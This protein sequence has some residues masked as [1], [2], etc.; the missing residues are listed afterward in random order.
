MGEGN[1]KKQ[2]KK[3]SSVSHSH[4]YDEDEK[5]EKKKSGRRMRRRRREGILIFSPYCLCFLPACLV[6][7]LSGR[8][9]PLLLFQQFSFNK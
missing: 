5:K 8:F 6:S 1:K 9:F 2:K 4:S 7:E 3:A